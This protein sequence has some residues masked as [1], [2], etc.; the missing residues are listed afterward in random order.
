DSEGDTLSL[1][2]LLHDDPIPLPDTLDFNVSNVVRVFLHF[3]TYSVTSSIL[4]SSG[5]EDTIFDPGIS[6]NRFYS[7]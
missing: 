4:L 7:F 6:I 5:S 3:F 2:R 1:E